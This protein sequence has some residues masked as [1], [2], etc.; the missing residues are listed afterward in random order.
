MIPTSAVPNAESSIENPEDFRVQASAEINAYLK[1]MMDAST[2]IHLANPDG[3]D[4]HTVICAIEP[5]HNLL[6]LEM[7]S[8]R[9][10][11]QALLNSGE[12][13][14]VAYL[15]AIK[16]QFELEGLLSVQDVS[17][18][19]LRAQIPP[20]LFRFQR[21]Q[22]YRVQPVGANPP[23]AVFRHPAMPDMLLRLRVVDLSM[24]GLG[25]Q[26][27]PEM[28]DIEPGISISGV[29]IELDRDTLIEAQLRLQH[30][31]SVDADEPQ[32]SHIG[33]A[34]TSLST[35]AARALQLYIDQ[36]QKRRRL[37]KL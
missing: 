2:R 8:D 35:D 24:G 15:D 32:P 11:V 29:Q 23:R 26:L 30:V 31:I 9:S 34:F 6:A 5:S 16:L 13:E 20:H 21:R 33:C 17:G 7:P 27:P 4:L 25:L 1:Q 37:L 18:A 22:A 14:A 19:V 10:R 3:L 28:P 12:V 36:T